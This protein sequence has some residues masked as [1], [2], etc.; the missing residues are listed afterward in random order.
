[1]FGADIASLSSTG[2]TDPGAGR[3]RRK[4]SLLYQL[5]A[6]RWMCGRRTLFHGSP[7]TASKTALFVVRRDPRMGGRSRHG[8]PR[9]MLF[10]HQLL[11]IRGTPWAARSGR[12]NS[13]LEIGVMPATPPPLCF[14]ADS[15]SALVRLGY[16]SFIACNWHPALESH[17]YGP[18]NWYSRAWSRHAALRRSFLALV[19]LPTVFSFRSSS[20]ASMLTP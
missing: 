10:G 4:L 17:P 5:W 15:I 6:T 14:M 11:P 20:S 16:S 8:L 19:I 7:S 1:M 12:L 13:G 18:G 3:L 9:F 2:R